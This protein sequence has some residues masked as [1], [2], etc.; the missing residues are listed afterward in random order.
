MPIENF[1]ARFMPLLK[2]QSESVLSFVG[3]RRNVSTLLNEK[4]QQV[5]V[6]GSGRGVQGRES[7]IL[8]AV[9]VGTAAEESLNNRN[10]CF[11]F[12]TCSC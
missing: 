8:S 1:S 3:L 2:S 7:T 4:F 12:S 5:L 6:P 11:R 10:D 9:D